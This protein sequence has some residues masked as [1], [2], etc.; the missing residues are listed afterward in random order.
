MLQCLLLCFP[1]M[2]DLRHGALKSRVIGL[3]S[4]VGGVL[5]AG[6]S[7]A[8]VPGESDVLLVLIHDILFQII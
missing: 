3:Q 7:H 4:C 6:G 1:Q 8:V 2:F 5:L